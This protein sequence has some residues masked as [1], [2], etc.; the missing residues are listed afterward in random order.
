MRTLDELLPSLDPSAPLAGDDPRFVDFSPARG[1]NSSIRLYKLLTEKATGAK[2]SLLIAGHRGAGKTTE[3][4]RLQADLGA[5]FSVLRLEANVEMDS[6]Q[7]VEEDL[8]LVL[9]RAV[10]EHVA[11]VGFPL[12]PDQIKPVEQWFVERTVQTE[13]G[14]SWETSA[15]AGVNA[16]STGSRLIGLF[17]GPGRALLVQALAARMDL[18]LFEDRETALDRLIIASGGSIRE[19]LQL[20]N[21][22]ALRADGPKIALIEV[23]AAVRS[24]RARLRDLV[25]ANGWAPVLGSIAAHKRVND[26]PKCMQ[27]L[28]HRLALK[29]NG[30]GWYDVHPLIAELPEVLA[31][32]D[33]ASA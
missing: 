32:R 28:F 13:W 12:P 5:R 33:A 15:Q 24:A 9:A 3:L 2:K 29:Y 31:A 11:S 20:V 23:D 7:I 22:C 10:L 6:Q 17:D 21:D 1:D 27:V 14:K 4:T 18:D 8:Y 26:D 30:D 16:D 19:L 25:N